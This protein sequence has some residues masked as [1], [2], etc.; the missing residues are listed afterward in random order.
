M[1]KHIKTCIDNIKTATKDILSGILSMY[2]IVIGV[3]FTVYILGI[4]VITKWTYLIVTAIFVLDFLFMFC[5][6]CI[7]ELWKLIKNWYGEGW[8]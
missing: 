3:C 6:T 8:F 2:V 7:E 1:N 5:F 4:D